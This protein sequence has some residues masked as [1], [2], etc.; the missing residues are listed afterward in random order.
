MMSGSASALKRLMNDL[1]ELNEGSPICGISAHPVM[2]DLFIWHI[3][4]VGPGEFGKRTSFKKSRKKVK[5]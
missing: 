5:T 1:K 2:D 4:L 3:N